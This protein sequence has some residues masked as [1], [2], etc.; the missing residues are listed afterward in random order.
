M[1][2]F[3]KIHVLL[4]LVVMFVFSSCRLWEKVFPP[5]YGCGSNGKNVGAE[6]LLS[7]KKEDKKAA[8]KARKLNKKSI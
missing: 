6:Q 8:R 2:Q 1:K 3:K 7:G 5:K 4:I